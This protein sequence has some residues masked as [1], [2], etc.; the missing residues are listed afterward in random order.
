MNLALQIEINVR[1]I[2]LSIKKLINDL[3]DLR[4][5]VQIFQKLKNNAMSN[6]TLIMIGRSLYDFQSALQK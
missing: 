1:L 3:S 5:S 2:L 4:K 6:E